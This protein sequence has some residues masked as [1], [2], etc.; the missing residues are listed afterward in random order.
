MSKFDDQL[1]QGISMTATFSQL[2][3]FAFLILQMSPQISLA[4]TAELSV[5][6]CR[7]CHA[8]SGTSS[9]IPSL[10]HKSKQEV[11]NKFKTFLAIKTESTIMHRYMTGYSAVE[12][13]DLADY[14]SKFGL[15]AK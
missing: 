6:S 7:I 11:L 12:R 1:L 9:E 4:A 14:I 13:E 2:F 15:V 3:V 10:A 5:L 8:Q